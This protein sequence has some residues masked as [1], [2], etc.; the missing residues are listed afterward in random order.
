MVECVK[1]CAILVIRQF[2]TKTANMQFKISF[3]MVP[4]AGELILT[5]P[6]HLRHAHLRQTEKTASIQE[7]HTD[8]LTKMS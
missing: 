8:S 7:L 1:S 4:M 5:K 2:L 3:L 6:K